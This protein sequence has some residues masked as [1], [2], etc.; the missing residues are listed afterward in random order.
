MSYMNTGFQ[1][2]YPQRY[3]FF[4][5]I[6]Q[7]HF[8]CP[9][10]NTGALPSPSYREQRIR[11]CRGLRD[12]CI[13]PSVRSREHGCP[14][15]WSTHTHSTVRHAVLPHA[16]R[17]QCNAQK[18]EF[19]NKPKPIFLF[20]T[21]GR[22]FMQDSCT[23]DDLGR[24]GN[25]LKAMCFN[26][27]LNWLHRFPAAS[28]A[29]MNPGLQSTLHQYMRVISQRCEC[30]LFGGCSWAFS[31]LRNYFLLSCGPHLYA[32]VLWAAHAIIEV[33]RCYIIS[34]FIYSE[35]VEHADRNTSATVRL[36]RLD[37]LLFINSYK[38]IGS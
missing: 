20:C 27:A 3:L 2:Q 30:N 5:S 9:E 35:I 18:L 7:V 25:N 21:H 29:V 6:Y 12:T 24:P 1:M 31:L 14:S 13:S 23:G 16:Q 8:A 19:F 10:G 38:C 15:T 36:R 33:C 28:L 32:L 17:H 37:L 34:R 22:R 4:L 11:E 26:S